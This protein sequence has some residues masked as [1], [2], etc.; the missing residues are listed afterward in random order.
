[1][2][3][4]ILEGQNAE[5]LRSR[6]FKDEST[7]LPNLR[8]LVEFVAAQL[9]DDHR[10]HPFGLVT[11]H[12]EYKPDANV[13]RTTGAVIFATRQG[14]RPADLLF[15]SAENELVALLLNT[16]RAAAAAISVRVSAALDGLKSDGILSNATVGLACAPTDSS[17]A[18]RLLVLSRER[19]SQGGGSKSAPP[20]AIH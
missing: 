18:E 8:H 15:R 20:E 4:A 9:V 7:G 12:F 3:G 11:I 14:L 2:S 6:S 5:R 17:E 13:N 19:A 16:E 10:R 1:V